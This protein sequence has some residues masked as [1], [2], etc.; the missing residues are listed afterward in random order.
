MSSQQELSKLKRRRGVVRGSI[1]RVDTRIKE[2]EDIGG[3][4]TL[5]HAKQLA[6][7]LDTLDSDFRSYHL[8]IIDLL[9]SEEQLGEEQ[10]ALDKHDDHIAEMNY[11][12][13]RLYSSTTP[14]SSTD[15]ALL[16]RK[17]GHLIERVA[18]IET[19][20][21]ALA[22]TSSDELDPSLLEQ[23]EIQLS[24]YKALLAEIH[25]ELLIVEDQESIRDMLEQHCETEMTLFQ[26]SHKI[27]KL[28]KSCHTTS[29]VTSLHTDTARA[30]VKLPKIE[31]PSFDGDIMKWKQFWDQFRVSVHDSSNLNDAERMVYLQQA[32]K[33]GSARSIIEGLAQSGEQYSEA[34][35]CLTSRFDR[36]R[37][38]HQSHVKMIIE[39]P[40]IREGN[41]K[42]IRKLHDIIQQHVRA[43]RSIG[44]E[45]SPSFITS[46]IEL[47][48]DT[49][50]M[51]EWRHTQ[52][53]NETPHYQEIL[54]FLDQR[55]QASEVS[56]PSRKHNDFQS[57][58]KPFN[59][60]KSVHAYAANLDN[61]YYG[62]C[63]LCKPE[64]HPLYACPKF[65]SHTHDKKTSVIKANNLCMNCLGK[66]HIAS[67]HIDARS[68]KVITIH[69]CIFRETKEMSNPYQ[70]LSQRQYQSIPR[71]Q[72]R[73]NL[74]P[75]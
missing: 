58:R 20:I 7:K 16:E 48:L 56:T 32:L 10:E 19:R 45:P 72:W 49:T 47:K 25:A 54:Q 65:K 18:S 44:K 15:E 50:T 60:P 69:Y 42:E 23:N 43:L 57:S 17:L 5:E 3:P 26:C 22:G 2:L 38:I 13:N 67:P 71:Q 11:R 12:L 62:H 73:S 63:L 6:V 35:E 30:G 61:S 66:G 31:V 46:I 59:K 36:P 34:I 37:L 64:K 55:A 41:G 9:E 74:M 39:A 24:D 51:F 75:F 4:S 8:P 70:S 27:R 1:T 52:S 29:S 53:Q 68:A 33:D 28:L 14:T 40:S 21:D